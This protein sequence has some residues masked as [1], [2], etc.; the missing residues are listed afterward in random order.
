[1]NSLDG[2]VKGPAKKY[3]CFGRDDAIESIDHRLGPLGRPEIVETR[4][5]RVAANE[6]GKFGPGNPKAMAL[7]ITRAVTSICWRPGSRPGG[8]RSRQ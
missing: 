7:T 3:R 5:S 2:R 1:M 8:A 4:P 6:S